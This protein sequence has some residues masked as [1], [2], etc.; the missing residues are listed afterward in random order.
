MV[1]VKANLDAGWAS[2]TLTLVA[3]RDGVSLG[4]QSVTVSSVQ[5]VTTGTATIDLSAAGDGV[6]EL[7]IRDANGN[8]AWTNNIEIDEAGDVVQATVAIV[9]AMNADATQA[10]ART[11][12]ATAAAEIV[13]IHRSAE[14]V[15]AG[16]ALYKKLVD[17]DGVTLRTVAEVVVGDSGIAIVEEEI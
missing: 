16:A 7:V 1:A 4:T 3:I 10:A 17:A 15:T 11:A 6:V 9:S 13:K 14:A 2:S 5:S 12:S 8:V